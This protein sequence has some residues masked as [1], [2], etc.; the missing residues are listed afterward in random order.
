MAYQFYTST[1]VNIIDETPTTKRF[2]IKLPET[3][4]FQ[5][6]A[7]QFVMLDMPINHKHTTRSYSI[8]SAPNNENIIELIIVIKEQGS[9]T[10]Y[11]FSDVKVGSTIE[12]SQALGKL[13]L[14]EVLTEDICFICTGT[15]VAPFRSQIFDIFQ[16]NIPHQN[17]YLVFGNRTQQD[18]LYRKEFEE[19]AK[20][21]SSF[22]FI[23]VLS[24]ET[25]ES[26]GGK[27]GY[28]HEVYKD[29]FSDVRP[30]WFYIC[31]WQLM[32][33]EARQNLE[34]MGYDRKRI[35]FEAFD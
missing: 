31:G 19:L 15:G 7:G 30:A 21:E 32:L 25:P 23:P 35:R 26:W 20:K 1:V 9:G 6:K 10:T 13:F 8:A 2:Y 24:R 5:F 4:D 16:K 33:R 34:T 18:I 22:H 29:L 12:V 28:V 11:L 27:I 3:V 14:P 17:V